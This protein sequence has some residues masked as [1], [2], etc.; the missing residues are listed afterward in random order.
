MSFG[1]KLQV[2][3]ISYGMIPFMGT[4]KQDDITQ[5]KKRVIDPKAYTRPLLP[6]NIFPYRGNKD[7][8]FWSGSFIIYGAP[9]IFR[10]IVCN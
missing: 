4:Y 8:I 7:G 10:R 1:V 6:T 3:L 9:A 5:Y 2:K